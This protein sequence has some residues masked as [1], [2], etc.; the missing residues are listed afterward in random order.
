LAGLTAGKKTQYA[1]CGFNFSPSS[2]S[3][4]LT[5]CMELGANVPHGLFHRSAMNPAFLNF[6]G[7]AVNDFTP[8]RFSDFFSGNAH[9]VYPA[10]MVD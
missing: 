1:I 3:G 8:M 4:W 7:T 6:A 5:T 10:A 9:A 2:A